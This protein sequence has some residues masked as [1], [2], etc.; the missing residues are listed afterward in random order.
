MFLS[1]KTC[2][3]TFKTQKGNLCF[4]ECRVGLGTVSRA[5]R[6]RP[7]CLQIAGA[8][9]ETSTPVKQYCDGHTGRRSRVVSSSSR[10]SHA[11][12]PSK[13]WNFR[14][15]VSRIST[16]FVFFGYAVTQLALQLHQK[17]SQVVCSNLSPTHLLLLVPIL[18]FFFATAQLARQLHQ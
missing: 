2:P 15:D 18:L 16:F 5:H 12:N 6:L 17:R 3:S 13:V 4:P 7:P 8:Q 1:V 10:T 14:K 11:P 9:V